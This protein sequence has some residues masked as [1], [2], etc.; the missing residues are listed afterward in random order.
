MSEEVPSPE[1]EEHITHE[2]IEARQAAAAPG[3]LRRWRWLW[4][5]L[6]AL[7]FVAASVWAA[8]KA[9][10]RIK[11]W[12]S[13]RLARE[14]MAL[15][16]AQKFNE[17][18]SK[19]RD[20]VQIKN[21]EPE[22]WRAIARLLTRTG[23]NRAALE[24]W[25]RLERVGRLT[26]EDRR[27]Y[28]TA[29]FLG[30]NLPV[31]S[32]QVEALL[33]EP[34]AGPADWLLG[35]Q[36]AVR[37]QEGERALDYTQ[38]VLADPRA[39]PNELFSASVLVLS[40]TTNDSPPHLA[41]WRE[42]H[43]LAR[44]PKNPMSLTA[45]AFI[46]QHPELAPLMR[47]DANEPFFAPGE[48]ADRL[49]QHPK[50]TP[51][52][53]LLA[54]QVRAHAEPAR[55]A[56][57][58]NEA[59]TR[60]SRGDDDTLLTLI[61]WLSSI[62]QFGKVLDLITPERAS[63]RREFF[64]QRLD[65]LAG[66][67][68][69]KEIMDA[70]S[71]PHFPIDPLQE[72]IYRA[73]ARAHLGEETGAKNEWQRAMDAADNVDKLTTLAQQAEHNGALDTAD[74]AWARVIADA[75]RTRVAYEARLRIAEQLGNTKTAHELAADRLRIWPDDSKARQ[76]ELYLRLLL[77]ATP[78]EAAAAEPEA[79][80]L[81]AADTRSWDARKT[82]AL[83]LLRQNRP[84]AALETFRGLIATANPLETPP[85]ALAVRARAL[86][87]S[88]W[89]EEA[90]SDARNLAATH[91]LPEERALIADLAAS[92]PAEKPAAQPATEPSAT[93]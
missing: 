35:A 4:V 21:T 79:R 59:M 44:D 68:R 38:R 62:G 34:H 40:F 86:A 43:I 10:R 30:E 7:L 81:V 45:L 41:G 69:W 91:L 27:E 33:H 3:T 67:E 84:G 80:A 71:D 57:L 72:H 65:A 49:E 28:A 88:G 51:F 50:T 23:Q 75:P 5:S 22:A 63:Q 64:V 87:D 36:L 16:D 1:R 89:K 20:A 42:L 15:M 92:Q 19:A 46:A 13:R 26:T 90:A 29:A 18:A 9:A 17:A 74:A 48:L 53:Q 82:L 11:G 56:E 37:Q 60:F 6:A 54:L 78:E 77:G 52:H 83:A 32:R 24:W 66:L 76:E 55:T 25:S 39:T 8:P 73:I 93:P 2:E 12:Q 85:S 61:R 14:A 58:V 70:F 31:A 47:A